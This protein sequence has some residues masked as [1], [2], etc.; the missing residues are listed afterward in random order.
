MSEVIEPVSPA[1]EPVRE[2]RRVYSPALDI[3]ETQEG[4]VLEADLPG[5][6]PHNLEIRVQD[7]VLHLYGK[8]TW[9]TLASAKVLH[10]EV[11]EEDFYRSFILSDERDFPAMACS[12]PSRKLSAASPERFSSRTF[13]S[14][15]SVDRRT[16]LSAASAFTLAM[17]AL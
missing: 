10:E 15:C 13:S 17:A 11:H 6:Q 3:Y 2:P 4:L 1:P 12:H 5:V 7:N 14:S 8:V 9:P 16:A